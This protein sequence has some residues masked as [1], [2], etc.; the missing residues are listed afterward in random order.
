MCK[1]LDGLLQSQS[2][3]DDG[4]IRDRLLE[5]AQNLYQ[6]APGSIPSQYFLSLAWLR[7][8]EPRIAAIDA[9]DRLPVCS[10]LKRTANRVLLVMETAKHEPPEEWDRFEASY[11]RLV[12]ELGVAMRDAGC[13]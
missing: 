7:L 1:A 2:E 10:R 11:Q 13:R 12:F 5:A 9:A 3:A 6:M 4:E 8:L